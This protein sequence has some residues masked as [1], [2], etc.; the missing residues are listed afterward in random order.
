MGKWGNGEMGYILATLD[1]PL[2]FLSTRMR[3]NVVL[4]RKQAH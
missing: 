1:P 2:V 3:N 4:V